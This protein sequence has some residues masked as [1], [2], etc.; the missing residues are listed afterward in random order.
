[1]DLMQLLSFFLSAGL[2]AG[3]DFPLATSEASWTVKTFNTAGVA[4]S[5]A[6]TFRVGKCAELGVFV[7]RTVARRNQQCTLR[8]QSEIARHNRQCSRALPY[9]RALP[10]ASHGARPI[11]RRR[12]ESDH[13]HVSARAE[14]RLEELFI[15]DLPSPYRSRLDLS[16]FRALRKD[17]WP[18]RI[19]RALGDHRFRRTGIPRK[20]HAAR[21]SPRA[22][23]RAASSVRPVA[24]TQRGLVA[25]DGRRQAILFHR[26]AD[27]RAE[28]CAR[29][30]RAYPAD[31]FQFASRKPQSEFLGRL[32]RRA[33]SQPGAAPSSSSGRSRLASAWAMT[34]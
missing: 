26:H 1:M 15:P 28:H 11:F 3:A 27:A 12:E 4:P 2:L 16:W 20:A 9:Q 5:E 14:R 21:A 34:R 13:T 33:R 7:G 10:A 25:G 19:H 31:R 23:E 17:R 6:A 32:Q 18:S 8:L 22:Q 24:A 29:C 30:R